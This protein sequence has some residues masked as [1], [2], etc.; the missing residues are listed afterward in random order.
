[1]ESEILEYVCMS[2]GDEFYQFK[3]SG[4]GLWNC[5][6]RSQC[7]GFFFPSHLFLLKSSLKLFFAF[8]RC[9]NVWKS[10]IRCC[11]FAYLYDMIVLLYNVTWIFPVRITDFVFDLIVIVSIWNSINLSSFFQ[12]FLR[13]Q[14]VYMN[15]DSSYNLTI[16]F[17]II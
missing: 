2:M 15:F 8:R 11:W 1:M 16:V 5:A 10:V 4:I 6:F 13:F 17:F 9:R 7:G 3:C 12:L 14:H